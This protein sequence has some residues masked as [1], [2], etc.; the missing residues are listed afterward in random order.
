VTT[1]GEDMEQED[2]Q[3]TEQHRCLVVLGHEDEGGQHQCV[4]PAGHRQAHDAR[5]SS[6]SSV[7]WM[8]R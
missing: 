1:E 4:L 3:T 6:V 5:W 7:S 8:T 2:P